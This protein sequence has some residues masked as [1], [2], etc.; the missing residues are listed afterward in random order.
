MKRI[1]DFNKIVVNCQL[2]KILNV[3]IYILK[4]KIIPTS[5][6]LTSNF[7]DLIEA[8]FKGLQKKWNVTGVQALLILFI[9]AVG[10]SLTGY[11]GRKLMTVFEI[12][13]AVL[14]ILIYIL[15]VT[16]IWPV[17]VLIVS[18]PF[19]QFP[20]FKKYITRIGNRLFN[21]KRDNGIAKRETSNAR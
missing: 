18:I 15:L 10:G 3:E 6:P 16:I 2:V 7:V 9:F 19:G 1:E 21:R 4:K 20:F 12:E 13:I 5:K 17:A 14:Y 8:M 11:A